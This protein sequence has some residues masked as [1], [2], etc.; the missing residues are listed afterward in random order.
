MASSPRSLTLA[1][2]GF[3]FRLIPRW[4]AGYNALRHLHVIHPTD[5]EMCSLTE[6]S[7][8]VTSIMSGLPVVH[9]T[10]RAV[11]V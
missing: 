1:S 6:I 9:T 5:F 4:G 11:S 3:V 8:K 10:G 7:L 2:L